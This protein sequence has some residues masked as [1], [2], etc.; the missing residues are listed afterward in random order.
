MPRLCGLVGSLGSGFA[1]YRSESIRLARRAFL[2]RLG[3]CA[4]VRRLGFRAVWDFAPFGTSR[5][6]GL[7]AVRDFAPLSCAVWDSAPFGTWRRL[8]PGA[9]WDFAPFGTLRR[10]APPSG[11]SRRWAWRR[12]AVRPGR[13]RQGG[14]I[15]RRHPRGGR[16]GWMRLSPSRTPPRLVKS[17]GAS[18]FWRFR[19]TMPRN[20]SSPEALGCGIGGV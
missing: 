12:S 11:I 15:S 5:R 19:P 9:V 7:R 4:S 3:F 13:S 6:S 17:K 1:R 10:Q 14:P 8:A 2:R 18:A 20:A 16:S